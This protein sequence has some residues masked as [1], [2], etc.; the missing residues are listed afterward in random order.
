MWSLNLKRTPCLCQVNCFCFLWIICMLNG[1]SS[2]SLLVLVISQ[3]CLNKHQIDD[4]S[5]KNK[6]KRLYPI[7][8]TVNTA[9]VKYIFFKH[10]LCYFWLT[11]SEKQRPDNLESTLNLFM[12][13]RPLV[14]LTWS[15]MIL[16]T[17]YLL[18][19]KAMLENN[20]A[21]AWT[22]IK[23]RGKRNLLK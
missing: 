15:D 20:K 8:L 4:N 1:V 6:N 17:H 19:K 2:W 11:R 13:K 16:L 12:T 22:A 3:A 21:S 9:S 7:Q 10:N 14:T 18:T 5:R 23:Q